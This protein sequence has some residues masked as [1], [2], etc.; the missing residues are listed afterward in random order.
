MVTWHDSCEWLGSISNFA[1]FRDRQRQ[2][3]RVRRRLQMRNDCS[4]SFDCSAAEGEAA[5]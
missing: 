1:H 2:L 5:K 3:L 4:V